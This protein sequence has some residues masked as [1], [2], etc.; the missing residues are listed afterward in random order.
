MRD[1]S[2]ALVQTDEGRVLH[3]FG[4]E[5]TILLDGERANGRPP[6][7]PLELTAIQ[8]QERSTTPRFDQALLQQA[9]V[10]CGPARC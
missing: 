2:P 7:A 4:Q 5:V 9:G 8:A 6:R 3:A 10:V 1:K